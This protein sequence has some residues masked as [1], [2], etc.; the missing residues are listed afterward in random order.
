MDLQNL[1][2]VTLFLLS[3]HQKNI[4]LQSLIYRAQKRKTR[5]WWVRPINRKKRQGFMHNLFRELK[6][7]DHEESLVSTMLE[8]G[9]IS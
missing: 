7:I 6:S 8:I 4:A 9:P 1:G 2:L 3:W 5:R